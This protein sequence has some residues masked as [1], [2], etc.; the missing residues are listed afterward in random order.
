MHVV[1]RE[2]DPR[3]ELAAIVGRSQK[4]SDYPVLFRN[5]KGTTMPVISNIYGSHA[6]LCEIIGTTRG[7][8]CR[9]WQTLVDDNSGPDRAYTCESAVAEE[10]IHGKI[11]DLPHITYF[12]HDAGPYITAGVFL[13]KEPDT[14]VPN[15][16]FCRSMMVSDD[17]LRVRLAPPHDITQYQK[18][19]EARNQPLEVAILLGP[20]PEV[21]MAACASIPVEQDELALAARL[22]GAPVPMRPCRHI[23]MQVPGADRSRD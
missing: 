23:D 6:R 20:P 13:A 5:V 7:N 14:G 9:H 19:A 3:F 18:K 2:V 11:S 12:E 16:S 1:E 4:E 17:E 15:L 8:F 22:M 10:R 21:F